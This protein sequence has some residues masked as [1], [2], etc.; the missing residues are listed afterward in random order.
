M[1][2][3]KHKLLWLLIILLYFSCSRGNYIDIEGFAQGSTYHLSYQGKKDFTKEIDSL[4]KTLDMS[5][6]VWEANSIISRINRNDSTVVADKIFTEVFNKA[7]EVFNESNGMFD[8][9]VG[10]LVKTWGFYNG[11]YKKQDSLEIKK[12]LSCVGMNKIRLI[13][14]KMVKEN[15]S[16]MLDMNA[17][18][19]GYS[20]DIVSAFLE[21]NN[22]RNYLVEIGGELKAK[23][24]NSKGKKWVIGI[25]KPVDGNFIPGRNLQ[26]I[27]E[28]T[29][30]AIAT[31]GDYRKF[32]VENGI[33]YSHHINPKTGYPSKSTLLSTTI[34]SD[35]CM[36]A[37]AYGTA[38]MVTGLEKSIELLK[39]HSELE[40]YLIYCDLKGNFQVYCTEG[41]KQAL[42]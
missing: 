41:L 26:A 4:L 28:I 24:K 13:N 15:D 8:I 32:F 1:N 5:L 17:I 7:R 19:Q 39:R 3:F 40:A 14:G 25:D 20:V 36:T 10:R 16:I 33:K 22:I 30:K 38:C 11:N 23:G 12:L 31:S 9:T 42:K 27:I 35:N 6:S 21:F 18:A 2:Y 37:D 29:N 34:V